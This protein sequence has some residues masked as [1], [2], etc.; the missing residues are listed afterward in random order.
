M[1]TCR[2]TIPM[3]FWPSN[4]EIP[5]SRIIRIRLKSTSSP[6][7]CSPIGITLNA[8]WKV[9]ID[10]KIV[11]KLY[12]RPPKSKNYFTTVNPKTEMLYFIF[13]VICGD[14]SNQNHLIFLFYVQ[15]TS[16]LSAQQFGRFFLTVPIRPQIKS[17]KSSSRLGGSTDRKRWPTRSTM[18]SFWDAGGGTRTKEKARG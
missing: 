12:L 9:N 18:T 7:R 3:A 14:M 1:C 5:E 13:N 15:V 16:G 10:F 6:S 8:L 2:G 11:P 4:S 17:R